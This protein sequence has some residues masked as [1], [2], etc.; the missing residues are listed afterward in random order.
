MFNIYIDC[1]TVDKIELGTGK[2]YIHP[3]AKFSG[4][5]VYGCHENYECPDCGTKFS[6]ELPDQ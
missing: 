6:V 3:N 5:C 1:R 4:E 2:C